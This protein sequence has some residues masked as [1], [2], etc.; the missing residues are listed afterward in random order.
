[1][2]VFIVFI[3]WSQILCKLKLLITT[4]IAMNLKYFAT[5]LAKNDLK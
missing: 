4:N 5:L 2:L 1:M 3:S